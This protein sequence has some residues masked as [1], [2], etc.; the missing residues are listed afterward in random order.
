MS[1]VSDVDDPV[2]VARVPEIHLSPEK[3]VRYRTFLLEQRLSRCSHGG[4]AN[5]SGCWQLPPHLR[6]WPPR[7]CSSGWLSMKAFRRSK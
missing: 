4:R 3:A 1:S 6:F 2:V 7:C 5:S